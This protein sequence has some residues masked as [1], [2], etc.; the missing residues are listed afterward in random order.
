MIC[1]ARRKVIP[2]PFAQVTLLLMH[3]KYQENGKLQLR[4]LM[5]ILPKHIKKWSMQHDQALHKLALQW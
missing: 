4:L 3:R 5:Y 2:F 1:Y